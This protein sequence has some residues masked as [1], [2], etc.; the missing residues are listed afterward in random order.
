MHVY[1]YILYSII[2]IAVNDF[3]K[4]VI[5]PLANQTE[6]SMRVIIKMEATITLR[7]TFTQINA[8]TDRNGV[9]AVFRRVCTIS[10]TRLNRC[11]L[12]RSLCI[13]IYFRRPPT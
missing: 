4:R 3:F 2:H 7:D 11:C 12:S 6:I 1:I 8:A 13:D 10:W 5:P 9:V